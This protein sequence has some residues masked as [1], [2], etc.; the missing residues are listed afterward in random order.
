MLSLGQW[1]C[2]LGQKIKR[3]GHSAKRKAYYVNTSVDNK[4]HMN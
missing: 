2:E 3:P 1:A 4:K